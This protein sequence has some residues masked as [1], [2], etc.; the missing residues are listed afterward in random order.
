M[1]LDTLAKYFETNQT[2][3]NK[4]AQK[5]LTAYSTKNI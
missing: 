5:E 3:Y 4:H 2:I 1:S